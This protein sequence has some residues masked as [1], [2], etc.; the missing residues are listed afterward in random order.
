MT[1][2]SVCATVGFRAGGDDDGVKYLIPD[3]AFKPAQVLDIAFRGNLGEL[4]F[5]CEY[6][7]VSLDDEVDLVVA[8]VGPEV[9]D[10]SLRHLR[11]H[12]H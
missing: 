6:P 9:T 7:A 4:D 5:D 12:P 8:P 3:L 10:A 11:V 2:D 1:G